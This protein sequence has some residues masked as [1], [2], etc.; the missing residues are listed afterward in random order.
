MKWALCQSNLHPSMSQ[1]LAD[2]AMSAECYDEFPKMDF[3]HV[4]HVIHISRLI[5]LVMHAMYALA[6]PC[7]PCVQH[8]YA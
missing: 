5:M 4:M 6:L 3:M 7:M 8:M 1:N 2:G